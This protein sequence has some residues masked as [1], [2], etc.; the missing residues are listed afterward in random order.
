VYTERAA[1]AHLT[2][3]G[4]TVGDARTQAVSILAGLFLLVAALLVTAARPQAVLAGT[5]LEVSFTASDKPYDDNTDAALLTCTIESDTGTDDVACAPK[6]GESGTFGSN[7]AGNTSVTADPGDFELSGADAEAYSIDSVD[8]TTANIT[9]APLTISAVTDTRTYDDTDAS[10]AE[11]TIDGLVGNDTASATQSFDSVNALG[12]DGSTLSVTAYV[13]TDGN[14]GNNYSVDSSATAA[15]TIDKA[16]LTIS[17]VTDRKTYDDSDAS[18]ETPDTAGLQG[19]DTVTAAQVFNS[20]HASSVHG[21]ILSVSPGYTV[22]DGNSGGN[23]TVDSSGTAL[24]TIDQAPLDI[25]AVTQTRPYDGSTIS[26]ATPTESG[27]QGDDTVTGKTQAFNSRN[28]SSVGGRILTVTAYTVNDDNGGANYSVSTHTATGTITKAPLTV[29][30]VVNLKTADNNTAAANPPSVSGTIYSPDSASFIETYDTAAAGSAKTL[31]PSGSVSDGNSGNNYSYNFVAQNN[32][33]I[34]PGPVSTLTFTAQPIDTKTNTPIYNLCVPS[35]GA[36]PC[37]LSTAATPSTTVKVLAQDQYGNRAGPGSPGADAA[38]TTINVKI[39]QDTSSGTLLGNA[40]TSNGVADFLDQLKI[41]PTGS[42]RLFA[43]TTSGSAPTKLSD[44]FS[45][46]NDLEACVGGQCD[47]NAASP[48]LN[49]QTAF[50]KIKNT[51]LAFGGTNPVTL[52]TQFSAV[53]TGLCSNPTAPTLGQTTE[54]KVQGTGVSA[55]KPAFS[56]VLIYPKRTIQASGFTSR[57][58]PQFNF[59]LGATRLDGGSAPWKA[60]TSLSNA[61]LTDASG[62]DGAG[63]YWGYLADCTALT[64]AQRAVNPCI[65]LRT[66]QAA[67]LKAAV[68]PSVMSSADFNSLGYKDSDLAIVISKPYPWDGKFTGR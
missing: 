47:N 55:T 40:N 5:P 18:S 9:Q 56:V 6:P 19:D 67:T 22:N 3:R 28:A 12:V 46:V 63:F 36:Q 11:P 50:G 42:P 68:V 49:N 1:S 37:T 43:S 32:G 35:G 7:N 31:T 25:N 27:L 30:A 58:V 44:R 33:Q 14:E 2:M 52:T 29:T 59:C 21:R 57:G 8:A 20:R 26:T 54:I 62:P 51:D 53:Q 66:K 10:T 4:R 65:S 48:G 16:S 34:R 13:V 38:N 41:V 45:I 61:T 15:G 64:P 23:Y 17:A 24:G 60:R 39:N